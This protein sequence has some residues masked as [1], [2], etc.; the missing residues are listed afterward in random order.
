M[1]LNFRKLILGT[2]SIALCAACRAHG[3][4]F[5]ETSADPLTTGTPGEVTRS[6]DAG[7]SDGE[8]GTVGQGSFR[9][10]WEDGTTCATTPPVEVWKYTASTYIFRQSICTNFEAPFLYLLLGDTRALLLD[11]GT[12]HADVRVPVETA[13]AEW[14]QLKGLASLPLVVAHTHSHGDHVKGDSFFRNRPNTTVVGYPPQQVATFFTLTQWPTGS[15]T[16]DLGGRV[17]DVVPLPG[18]ESAHIA[19]YDTKEQILFTG[20]TLYPG[21]LYIQNW[22][23]YRSSVRRLVDFIDTRQLPVSWVLGAHI[24]MS[25][26]PGQDYAFQTLKHPNEHALPQPI[27]RLRELDTA[28]QAMGSTPRR[29]THPDFIIYP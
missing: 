20:D 22:N 12:G 18:H 29:E 15:A 21:R 4:S 23:S 28:A 17:L 19:I 25:T 13:M 1:K 11:S 7:S 27:E 3:E 26:T 14:I 2:A 6:A 9:P 8:G 16:F 24:E 5:E 10:H